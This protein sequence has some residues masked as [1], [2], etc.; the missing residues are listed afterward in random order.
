MRQ[1][2]FRQ[3][4]L[5]PS[6]I[7][8]KFLL[9][10]GYPKG[11]SLKFVGDHYQL[12]QEER[13]ALYRAVFP[14]KVCEERKRKTVFLKDLRGRPI[15]IDGHNVLITLESALRSRPLVLADDGFV[16]DVS[17]VFRSFRPTERTRHAWKLIQ[18]L[19]KKYNPG[20]ITVVLDAPLS[21]S[22]ELA[23]R[24]RHWMVE[25]GLKGQVRTEKMP[26]A[27]IF[28][29]PGIKATADSVVLDKADEIID[30]A[31]HVIRRRLH[32]K[33]LVLHD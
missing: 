25:A 16:R 10:R 19:L 6:Y 1:R 7:D 23:G 5:A 3:D 14:K 22:G 28:R 20:A 8:L 12:R 11:N 17:R 30:L 24:I 29:I 21:K 27:A 13:D 33:P 26:E 18:A 32:I 2:P 15:V 31:G 4:R 9:E